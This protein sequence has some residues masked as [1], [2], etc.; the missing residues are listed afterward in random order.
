MIPETHTFVM[1]N[2]NAGETHMDRG[3]HAPNRAIASCYGTQAQDET[4]LMT[5]INPQ[6]KELNEGIWKKLEARVLDYAEA[7]G[8]VWVITG[9]IIDS[10]NVDLLDVPTLNDLKPAVPDAFYKIVIR[11]DSSLLGIETLASIFPNENLQYPL[12]QDYLESIEEIQSQTNLDFLWQLDD[13]TEQTQETTTAP[14]LCDTS[15][16]SPSSAATCDPAVLINGFEA[17][18]SDSDIDR[19]WLELYNAGSV[20]IPVGGW[21]LLMV[22][23]E[24][25]SFLLP[26][27]ATVHDTDR[28]GRTINEGGCSSDRC[29]RKQFTHKTSHNLCR[30]I[31]VKFMY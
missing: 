2:F 1:D 7:F 15:Q 10:G 12:L 24:T 18:P 28:D 19:E 4:F 8:E 25:A 22:S 31:L 26:V 16:V 27:G 29:L 20:D 13:V 9:A 6:H 3:H 21:T 17:N 30:C 23:G 5:N 11:E 14:A